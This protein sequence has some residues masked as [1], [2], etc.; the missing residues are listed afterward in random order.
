M[1]RVVSSRGK[2]FVLLVLLATLSTILFIR[3]EAGVDFAN[4]DN[5][6]LLT[7]DEQIERS[8]QDGAINLYAHLENAILGQ[9]ASNEQNLL[10]ESENV[11]EKA[12]VVATA[13]KSDKKILK[14]NE[15][16]KHRK[17]NKKNKKTV[18]PKPKP[19]P[20]KLTAKRWKKLEPVFSI[21]SV[22]GPAFHPFKDEMV[23]ISD[24]S[25]VYQVYKVKIDRKKGSAI[26]KP[27]R[28]V[29]TKSRCSAPRYLKDGSILFYHDR[30]GNE[31]FQIGLITPQGKQVWLT[32][33]LK[34]K[35]LITRITKNYLY[36]KSNARNKKIFDLFRRPLP[37]VGN[38]AKPE[39]LYTPEVGI[40]SIS[41]VSHDE[42][43]L[44]IQQRYSN[45]HAELFLKDLV[46]GSLTPLTRPL[47]GDAKLLWIPLRFLDV[48]QSRLLVKT[49]YNGDFLRLAILDFNGDIKN[50]KPTF[51]TIDAMENLKSPVV[52]VL[53]NARTKWTYI[54][55]NEEGYSKLYRTRLGYNGF[56]TK[57]TPIPL[58]LEKGVIV[59]GDARSFGH[60][61]AIA[62]DGHL[63]AITMTDSE[64]PV[65]IY[66]LDLDPYD[67]RSKKS[68]QAKYWT[69]LPERLSKPVK[70]LEQRFASE[71]LI[72]VASFDGTMIPFFVYYPK[73]KMPEGGWPTI[74]KLHGGPES[75]SRPVFNPLIQFL[76]LSGYAVV[77]PNVRGS[78]G[79][80]KKYLDADNTIKRMDAVKDVAAIA[81][82]L[83]RNPK[84]NP[85]KLV[86]AG[87]SYG[88]Y[89]T[90]LSSV[91]IPQY[92]SAGISIVG[93]TNL[94]TFFKNTAE[95]RRR[96]RYE[97]YGNYH[98]QKE[99]LK[100][101]SPIYYVQNVKFPMFIIQGKNDERVPAAE[102]QTWYKKLLEE[103]RKPGKEKL[104]QSVLELFPD[105]G[106]GISKR[107]N[108]MKAYRDLVNWLNKVLF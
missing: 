93:M 97:E 60:S 108:R 7:S 20:L 94:L 17:L 77:M 33:D 11:I 14:K 107:S 45:V 83:Q 64:R 86:I 82:Y 42:T 16:K 80:G 96:M 59:H 26:G 46:D 15:K 84:V 13:P 39:K 37:L 47:C 98:T 99:F 76:V 100:S 95:F 43:Q 92:F 103:S 49:D 9:G 89:L 79:Y 30:G 63:M 53:S 3:A 41:L 29:N 104:K 54:E 27:V 67:T 36:Y 5:S 1:M 34:A 8:R 90:C 48:A 38:K 56:K 102:A 52:G 73:G 19:K 91:F 51:I 2:L 57:L 75:Q 101:I 70:E 32:N 72:K 18:K 78:R 55:V 69:L 61:S 58:P 81:E 66:L 40:A 68:K 105:E 31:N 87:G 22:G 4:S 71:E 12:A 62:R 6:N 21:S 50:N 24:E 85:K 65:N 10:E 106:H 74:I 25:G 88:G 44:V 28:L 35:H 23:Y